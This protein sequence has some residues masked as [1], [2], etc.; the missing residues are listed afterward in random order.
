MWIKIKKTYNSQTKKKLDLDV[1]KGIK[2]N[3]NIPVSIDEDNLFKYNSSS[4]YYNDICY[5]YTTKYK[6]DI[7][8]KDRQIEFFNN[9]LSVC[10]ANCEYNG[11]NQENKNVLCECFVKIEFP[12]ISEI[13]INK[14]KLLNNFG[15]VESLININVMK[16][17]RLLFRKKGLLFNIANYI[18][19]VIILIKILL[20]ILF[21][22]KGNKYFDNIINQIINNK[23]NQ[24]NKIVKESKNGNKNTNKIL[25]KK[26]KIK[27]KGPIKIK[28]NP[29]KIKK[30][31]KNI[32][33]RNINIMKTIGDINGKSY[34]NLDL[35]IKG[36]SKNFNRNKNN[37]NQ[38]CLLNNKRKTFINNTIINYNDYELNNLNY[39]E[40]LDI[41]KRK[42]YQYYFSL[43][44]MKH[45]IIFTFYTMNDY[46]SKIMKI[47]LFLFLFSLYYAISALFFKDS[48][49]Q[50]IYEDHGNFNFIYQIPQIIYS[51]IISSVFNA[52]IKYLSLSEKQIIKIKNIKSKLKQEINKTK[53]CL[54]IKFNLFFIFDFLFTII[55]WYYLSCFCAVYKNTQIY[56][57]KNVLICFGLSFIYPLFLNLIPGILRIP[58]LKSE[59]NRNYLYKISQFLQII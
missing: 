45:L 32:K 3:I 27:R 18:L 44:R 10:E 28:N 2:I 49:M 17:Y 47:S 40:A 19:I 6:T 30:K 29:P 53:K 16:C 34:S 8:L 5:T 31:S 35:D 55:F 51:N 1:C 50:K 42:Y 48:T 37:K 7:I 4:E 41:D 14:D 38:K 15:D 22:I 9:N 23:N 24:K 46:N 43:L 52:F 58:S 59:R 54:S 26:E 39:K 57:I 56:L 12:L 33:K 11:Y 21:I 13:V 36:N 25:G 20:L